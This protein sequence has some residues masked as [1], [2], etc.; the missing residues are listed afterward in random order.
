MSATDQSAFRDFVKLYSRTDR[1]AVIDSEY[2][3][4]VLLYLVPSKLATTVVDFSK[5]KAKHLKKRTHKSKRQKMADAISAKYEETHLAEE[6]KY[7]PNTPFTLQSYLHISKT[8]KDSLWI[9]SITSAS[10]SL[11]HRVKQRNQK[12]GSN[13]HSITNTK[14]KTTANTVYT[15]K[16]EQFGPLV[17]DDSDNEERDWN[18]SELLTALTQ[19]YQKTG[20][21]LP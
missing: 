6:F 10:R 1:C 14:A 7:L 12:N 21:P 11:V 3:Y 2:E 19:F 17:S 5:Q 9:V 16:L 18:N 4:G 20:V 15:N 13:V 8:P